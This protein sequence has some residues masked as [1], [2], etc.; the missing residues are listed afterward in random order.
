[1]HRSGSE[2]KLILLLPDSQHW[3]DAP[4]NDG[5]LHSIRSNPKFL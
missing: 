5:M 1:M 3:R 4:Y 2:D